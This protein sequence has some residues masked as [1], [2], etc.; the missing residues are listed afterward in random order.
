[1]ARAYGIGALRL[2]GF[3]SLGLILEA[4][5]GEEHLLAGREYKFR[6]AFGAL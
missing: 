2:A 4:L 6:S 1:L 5:V 3:A